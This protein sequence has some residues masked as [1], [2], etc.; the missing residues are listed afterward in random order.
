VS[1]HPRF[2]API[3]GLRERIQ[4]VQCDQLGR[5]QPNPL[6]L[7]HCR[8]WTREHLAYIRLT[9]SRAEKPTLSKLKI[10]FVGSL[11]AGA[12]I[13]CMSPRSTSPAAGARHTCALVFACCMILK[14]SCRHRSRS[15][16]RLPGPASSRMENCQLPITRTHQLCRSGFRSP[17]V[18]PCPVLEGWWPVRPPCMQPY[19][20]MRRLGCPR[21]WHHRVQA[22]EAESSSPDSAVR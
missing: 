18:Q 22:N 6:A 5:C 10:E 20:T 12:S 14:H 7:V 17:G 2:S 15:D 3:P 19:C 4:F 21:I 1:T 8:D 9:H 13:I 16:A 11:N